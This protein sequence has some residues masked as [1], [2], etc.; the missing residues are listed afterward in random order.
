M[1][2]IARLQQALGIAL[3]VVGIIYL[4][5]GFTGTEEQFDP[6]KGFSAI[7]TSDFLFRAGI[8]FVVCGFIAT[9]WLV[10]KGVKLKTFHK[11]LTVISVLIISSYFGLRCIFVA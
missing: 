2:L 3:I 9:V 8:I 5:L 1:E 6:E 4:N 7:E 10:F 11:T